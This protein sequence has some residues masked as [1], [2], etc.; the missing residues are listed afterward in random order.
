ME[1]TTG[2]IVA[3]VGSASD[4]VLAHLDGIDG[5]ET[6]ALR[7]TEPALAARRISASS[8]PWIV[9]DADPLEHVGAA[10]VEL[11]EERATLGTLELEIEQALAHFER[12]AV[13]PDYYIVLEPETAPETWRHWWC[14]ALGYRAPR[15]ILPAPSAEAPRDAAVRQLLRALPASRP[16]PKPSSWL[17]GLAME[18]PDRIGLRDRVESDPA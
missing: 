17:P 2:T 7:D 12:G 18:I 16:W 15:R 14:G 10:W 4:E 1:N 13:M 3:V 8:R 5:V 9:H 6:L 11:F